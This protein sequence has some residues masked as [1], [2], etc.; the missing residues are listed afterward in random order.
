MRAVPGGVAGRARELANDRL[1][2]VVIVGP[3][4]T[5]PAAAPGDWPPRRGVVPAGQSNRSEGRF[6]DHRVGGFEQPRPA[7]RRA[8]RCDEHER[9]A[10]VTALR[11]DWFGWRVTTGS[12]SHDEHPGKI[13]MSIEVRPSVKC[14]IQ[15]RIAIRIRSGMPATSRIPTTCPG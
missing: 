2:R 6:I 13:I 9:A 4:G 12:E 10:G 1:R 15:C 5:H 14:N 8:Q 11:I 3:S 7:A